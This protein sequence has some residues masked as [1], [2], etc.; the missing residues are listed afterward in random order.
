MPGYRYPNMPLMHSVEQIAG[1]RYVTEAVRAKGG[2]DRAA[3]RAPWSLV[4]LFL[5]SR[6][7]LPVAPSAIAPP[8]KA[9]TPI[10]EQVPYET[11]RALEMGELPAIIADFRQAARS[12]REAGFDAVEIHGAN[13]LLLD[14]FLQ[15]G[16]NKR[17]DTYGGTIENRARLK[18]YTSPRSGW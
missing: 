16:S 1:W 13:G 9:Y 18:K 3:D 7:S 10:S 2:A 4:P 15:D 11:P 14:Q 12:A 5:Q 17:T 6:G 8:G